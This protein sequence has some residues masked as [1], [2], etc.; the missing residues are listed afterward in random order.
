MTATACTQP[1]CGGTIE[2]GWCNVCGLA[3]DLVSAVASPDPATT[4]NPAARAGSIRWAMSRQPAPGGTPP[5]Q[6]SGGQGSPSQPYGSSSYSGGSYGSGTYGSGPSGPSGSGGRSGSG[7]RRG[8]GSRSAREGIGAGFV[9]VSPVPEQDPAAAILANPVVPE[10]R[11]EC[12]KCHNPVGQSSNGQPGRTEGHCAKCG[13]RFSFTPKLWPGDLVA[14]Q[15]E[16]LGCLAYGGLG[17]IYLARDRNVDGRLVV[18]KGLLNS[19]DPDA[20]EAAIAERRFLAQVT[21]R[22]IVQ[23][24]NF[25]QHAGQDGET[26]GY[27]VM[28]YLPGKSLRQIRQEA[29]QQ[30]TAIPVAHALAYALEILPAFGYLHD[31]QL[32]FCDF[33][34]D[35]VMQTGLDLKLIDL[36]GVWHFNDQRSVGYGTA[37]YQ[38]AEIENE[39]EGPTPSSDLYTVGRTLAVLTFDF[40]FQGEYRFRLPEAE[41]VLLQQESFARLLRRATHADPG[42]RFQSAAEMAEAAT[43]VLREVL[44]AEDGEPRPA[45]SGLFSP[46]LRPVGTDLTP[47]RGAGGTSGGTVA[48]VPPPAAEII[49]GLPAPL[50]D[51]GDPAASYLATLGGLAPRQQADA[52]LGAVTGDPGVPPAVAG[53]Q[54]TRLALIRALI[55]AGDMETARGYLAELS[56]TVP[57]DWRIPWYTGLAELAAGRPGQA[58]AGFSAVYDELPGELAPKLALAFAAEAAGDLARARGYFQTVWTTDRSCISAAFG[59]ARTALAGRDRVGAIAAVA[60]VP[61]TSSYHAAAQ[62]AAVRLLVAGGDGVAAADLSQAGDR[63]GRLELDDLRRGQLEVEILSA[64][65]EAVT[66]G[67]VSAAAGSRRAARIPEAD[68]ILGYEPS[69]K[70]LR[71]GLERGY[72][73]LA[74]LIPDPARRIELVDLANSV[75]PRTLF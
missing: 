6:G 36:G 27:I 38:A 14:R 31:H 21:H 33:K 3:P 73:T 55:A 57:D 59:T 72:R 11:R 68:R 10:H 39:G 67:P 62:I 8:S 56:A 60:A 12:G 2:D 24:Y 44:S 45:F 1:G 50:A 43:G 18:L 46:E 49:A 34:P 41:P 52:L 53:S 66:A 69:E 23:I 40:P 54:E 35:N 28:Q 19:G 51:G 64:A 7:S 74:S 13:T 29:R 48:V 9:E 22:N 37:G 26:A 47:V 15:Y 16:V 42:R 71:T 4:V 25:V 75:R 58:Q 61:D 17:W 63:L 20:M 70:A 32:L 5:V 65:I 30:G